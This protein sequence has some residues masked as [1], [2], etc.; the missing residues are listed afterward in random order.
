MTDIGFDE[1]QSRFSRA[2][3]EARIQLKAV[4]DIETAA[5]ERLK[6]STREHVIEAMDRVVN[7]VRA[8]AVRLGMSHVLVSRIG[9]QYS[10]IPHQPSL[11]QT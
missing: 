1:L 11:L 9:D 10:L 3:E 5:E 2:R 8:T 7:E 4:S 6:E